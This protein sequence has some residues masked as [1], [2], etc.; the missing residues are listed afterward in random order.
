MSCGCCK[1][2][3]QHGDCRN[4]TLLDL[5]GAAKAAKTDI[6]HVVANIMT[7]YDDDVKGADLMDVKKDL[8]PQ[9]VAWQM[10]KSS[11]ERRFTLGLAYPANRPDVSR[12]ADGFRDFVSPEVLEQAAWTYLR[13]G[14]SVG[15]NHQDGTE[16]HGTVVESYIWRGDPWTVKAADGTT[17]T[18]HP[19]DWVVG[20]QWDQETWQMI[21]SGQLN[22]F[23]PQGRATRRAA[24]PDTVA[25]LRTS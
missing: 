18:I 17:Q 16:G 24:D 5:Q 15:I 13:K 2:S 11:D 9:E 14:G 22:G 6:H 10:I 8:M 3:K 1:P 23:S 19:N 20:V 21:K 25:K 12:A 7:C 4:I